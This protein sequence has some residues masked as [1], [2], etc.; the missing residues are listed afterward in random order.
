MLNIQSISKGIVIDHIKPGMG[1]EI[2]KLLELDKA[3]FSVALI[4]N[5]DSKKYG[6]KDI[7]K[8][9]NVIDI[10]FKVLGLMDKGLTINIIE[11]E[12][13]KEKIDMVLPDRVEGFIKCKNPRCITCHEKI[14]N[15]FVLLNMEKGIY[16]CNYCDHLYEIGGKSE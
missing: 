10:D 4:M 6:K 16:R 9:D 15:K 7:I 3:E 12:K 2:F 11:N 8:I 14:E 5:V 13:I 1:Y